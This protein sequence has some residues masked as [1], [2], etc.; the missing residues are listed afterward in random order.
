MLAQSTLFRYHP[1]TRRMVSARRRD[2]RNLEGFVKPQDDLESGSGVLSD[3]LE[4]V[5][6]TRDRAAFETLFRHFAPRVKGYMRRLGAD[7]ATAEELMQ[8]TMVSVWRKAAQF[9]R[10]KG[11][12][13]TWIFTVAR[14][15]G[16]DD[17]RRQRRPEYDPN[18]PA[19]VPDGELPP[20]EALAGWQDAKRVNA[21]MANLSPVE[22]A[23]LQLAFFDGL[24]H[25]AISERLSV[26]LGTV[27]SR[28]RLAFGKLRTALGGTE[29]AP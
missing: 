15:V 22:Q 9:D 1:A 20:D 3:C 18:D 25:S 12:A 27:K 4:S 7:P 10:S 16:V 19:F 26:P 29:A 14:N 28:L 21:A 2:G 24:S 17:W 6:A 11:S 5:G 13:S 8:E 23:V